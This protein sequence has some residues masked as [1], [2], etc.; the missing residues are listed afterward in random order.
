MLGLSEKL[1]DRPDFHQLAGVHHADTVNELRHQAHVVTHEDY[2]GAQVLLHAPECLQD[3]ALHHY[4]Q[5]AGRFVGENHAGAERDRHGDA[6]PLLHPAAQ[7]V[8]VHP[9]DFRRQP[10][11]IQE[12]VDTVVKLPVPRTRLVRPDGVCQLLSDA[13]DRVE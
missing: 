8:R 5:R 3:L 6:G 1:L 2:G 12:P 9:G 10:H 4:V 13:H 7:F 11:R